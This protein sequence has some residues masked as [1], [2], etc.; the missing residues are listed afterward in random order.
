MPSFI[1][2]LKKA[3]AGSL[4]YA[5]FT[6]LKEET[7]H[8]HGE[9]ILKAYEGGKLVH[10]Y[11]QSNIIVN[12]A[13]VL[14]A[15]LLKDSSE[16]AGGITYLAVGSGNSSWD[17]FDPPAPTTSQILLENEYYRK[18]ID[19]STFVHPETGEPTTTNTNIV[20]YVV[21]FGEAEAVGPMV[22]LSLFGGDATV[23]SNTG[24]MINWRTIPVIN[25]TSTMTLTII[26]RITA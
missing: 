26:F 16:P 9:L 11:R 19:M 4:R 14:I 23:A 17:M 6:I 1:E 18:Q 24:T 10:E 13:S 15:R 21:T 5:A 20:D 7:H 2:K 22:E 12:L 3:V 25:K 8:L